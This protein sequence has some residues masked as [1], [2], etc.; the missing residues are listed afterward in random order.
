MITFGWTPGV[1]FWSNV[2]VRLCLFIGETSEFIIRLWIYSVGLEE[3]DIGAC[4]FVACQIS[5]N[6]WPIKHPVQISWKI[7]CNMCCT[8]FCLFGHFEVVWVLK[9]NETFSSQERTERN[10]T[11]DRIGLAV[12]KNRRLKG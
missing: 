4:L 8:G 2:L 12:Y 11:G 1:F 5:T 6:T 3:S 7:N 10:W 9:M